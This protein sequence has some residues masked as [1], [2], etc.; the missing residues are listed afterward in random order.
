MKKRYESLDERLKQS[1]TL[2]KSSPLLENSALELSRKL[3]ENLDISQMD[4]GKTNLSSKVIDSTKTVF[5]T[6]QIVFN[7]Q[8]LD[9]A[10]LQQCFNY[11]NRKFGS[12][13]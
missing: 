8:E 13:Y 7:V 11:I 12:Q 5:T 10:K 2:K 1:K 4:F 6:P 3:K 9:E